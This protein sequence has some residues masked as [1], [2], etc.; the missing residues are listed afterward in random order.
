MFK[1]KGPRAHSPEFKARAVKR[2][3]AGEGVSALADELKVRRKLLYDWKRA[4]EDGQPLRVRGRPKKQPADANALAGEAARQLTELE[5]LVGRLT[6]ENRFF[7]GALQ[8]VAELRQA[9]G[10]SSSAARLPRSKR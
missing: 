9:K 5:A 3:R 10:A 4:V 8:N 6:L 1:A 7:R 2:M